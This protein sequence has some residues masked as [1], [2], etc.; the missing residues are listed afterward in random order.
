MLNRSNRIL[1]G[2]AIVVLILPFLLP[3]IM[4]QPT[5]SLARGL[6]L[7][8]KLT[9]KPEAGNIVS[10]SFKNKDISVRP[11]AYPLPKNMPWKSFIKVVAGIPGDIIKVSD[12]GIFINGKYWGP[13]HKVTSKG[14]DLKRII[15]GEYR[16]KKDWFLTLTSHPMSYDSRYYGPVHITQLKL[17]TALFLLPWD[18]SINKETLWTEKMQNWRLKPQ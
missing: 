3:N 1:I 13:V 18:N 9:K 14:K 16:L 17:A 12:D 5:G 2:S 8:S 10:I 7:K 6:Y 11:K 15:D 4:I